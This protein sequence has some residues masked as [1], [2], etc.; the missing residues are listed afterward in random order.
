L[1]EKK[2][3]PPF[4]PDVNSKEDTSNIDSTFTDEVIDLSDDENVSVG[5]DNFEDFT[6]KGGD[7]AVLD[8]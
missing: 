2:I 1:V 5:K 4:V 7:E 6:Y 8:N 3:R